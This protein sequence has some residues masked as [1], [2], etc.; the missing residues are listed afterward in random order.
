MKS[1]NVF[2]AIGGAALIL[3][4]LLIGAFFAAPLIAS[5]SSGNNQSASATPTTSSNTYCT[6]YWQN[7]ANELHISV[8]TLQQDRK[9]AIDDTINQMVK[10]GKLT[11]SQANTLEARV[12]ARQLCTGKGKHGSHAIIGQF[13]K[14]YRGDIENSVAS[15]LH[16]TTT[17]L[18]GDLKAG[19]SLSQI[20]TTQKVSST[21]L[22]TIVT[23]AV[24]SA[25][26]TAVSNGNLTQSQATAFSQS[27]KNHPALLNMILNHHFGKHAAKHTTL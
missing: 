20:A 5:A 2:F 14:K 26:N 1:R 6:D 19:Q 15:G 7:L 12:N 23:N 21:Q 13:L 16:L 17:Q 8:T 25:L 11:Q 4:G 27:L 3:L 10:D 18:T 24:Q 9:T 22:T